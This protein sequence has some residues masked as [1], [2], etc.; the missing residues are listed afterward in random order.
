ML[1]ETPLDS[2]EGGRVQR[3]KKRVTRGDT[4]DGMWKTV[5][6]EGNG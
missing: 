6:C 1:E 2:E 4:C 5:E 3:M